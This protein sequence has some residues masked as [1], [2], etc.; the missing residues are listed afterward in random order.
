MN[1]IRWGH[2]ELFQ[3]S[4]L[5]LVVVALYFYFEFKNKNK[6]S[7][8]FGDRVVRWLSQSVSLTQRRLQLTLQAIGLFLVVIAMARPQLGQ[9]EQEIK[10][11]GVEL[12]ILADVSESMLSEDI[13][14]SRLQQMKIELSKL[15]DLMPGNKTGLIAFAAS[16]ALMSPLTSDPGALKMYIDSLD[17]QSVSSQ[18]TNF[19]VALD[20]VKEAFDKGGVTQDPTLKTTR[21]VIIASDGEDQEKGALEKVQ[22]MVKEGYHFITIAYGTEQ[23]GTIPS[24]D[25]YGNLVGPKKDSSGQTIITKV[26]GDFLKSI[27][28]AGQGHFYFSNYQG[29]H[30]RQIMNDVDQYEKAEFA[31]SMTTQYDEKFYIPL[32]IGFIL[33]L[34]SL[35]ITDRRKTATVWKGQYET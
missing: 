23:G 26:K 8:Q 11:E 6:L 3:F 13:K 29:T 33:L 7:R 1:S 4:I 10:S 27:A 19:E 32:L 28:D 16:S 17:T 2:V 35:L 12:V 5:I 18:G 20:H 24:R 21:V 14:P 34:L 9:S 25:R 22:Q 15:I 31:S 30:L